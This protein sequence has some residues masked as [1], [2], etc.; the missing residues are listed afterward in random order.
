MLVY[1]VLVA[2][3]VVVGLVA[4]IA[5]R[6]A[7]FAI[8]RSATIPAPADALF[9]RVNDLHRFQDWS[10]WARMEPTAKVTYDGPPAGV[11]AAFAWQG[12]KTG[13]GRMTVVESKPNELVAMRLEFV[14]P[15]RCEHAARFTFAP[16]ADGTVVTW[17]MTGRN[18][19]MGKAFGLVMNM[20]RMIGTHFEDGLANLAAVTAKAAA[21]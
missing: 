19:F 2:V 16:A 15:M 1:V 17:T 18:G 14:A 8:T 10:P 3:V 6:P 21:A 20:D 7:D 4:L 9:A 11:G 13:A 5:T 12:K